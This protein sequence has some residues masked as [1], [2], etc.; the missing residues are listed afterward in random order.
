VHR[1]ADLKGLAGHRRHDHRIGA[2]PATYGRHSTGL[3]IF[4]AAADRPVP[5][6]I[7]WVHARPYVAARAPKP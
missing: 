4:V 1:I 6:I 7:A 3:V 5:M 2:R